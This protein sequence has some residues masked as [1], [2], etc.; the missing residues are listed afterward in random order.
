MTEIMKL[1]MNEQVFVFPAFFEFEHFLKF[2][3][4][5]LL[6]SEIWLIFAFP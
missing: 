5:F 2:F 3:P 1:G 6:F 4:P